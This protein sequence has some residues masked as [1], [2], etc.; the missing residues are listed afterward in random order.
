MFPQESKNRPKRKSLS[1]L[2]TLLPACNFFFLS[3][4]FPPGVY[5]V[6]RLPARTKRGAIQRGVKPVIRLRQTVPPASLDRLA[7]D[8]AQEWTEEKTPLNESL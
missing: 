5:R 4:C 6:M 8:L 2:G 1:L 3:D 7:D